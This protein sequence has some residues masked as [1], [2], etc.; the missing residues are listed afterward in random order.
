[1]SFVPFLSFLLL[2][3]R[4]S[5][6][7][8]LSP[9]FSFSSFQSETGQVCNK[10]DVADNIDLGTVVQEFEDYY[11]MRFGRKPKLV[12]SRD[13]D[14]T[15]TAADKKKM[16]AKA[17]RD[18][19]N[20]Y[21]SANMPDG[22][23]SSALNAVEKKTAAGGSNGGGTIPADGGVGD[24]DGG[25]IGITGTGVQL[26]DKNGKKAPKEIE[27]RMLKPIPTFGGDEVLRSLAE[28]ITRDIFTTDPGVYVCPFFSI[29][30]LS[31]FDF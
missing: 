9:P 31:I 15:G 13:G 4:S 10:F 24:E 14:G 29:L 17:R 11:E 30:L 20:N 19:R 23:K 28:N 8:S 26:S 12:R 27:R 2:F 21:T 7:H 18:K 6:L 1:V 5:F 3:F 25:G 16:A 22:L